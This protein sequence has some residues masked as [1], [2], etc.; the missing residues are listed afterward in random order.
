MLLKSDSYYTT[1]FRM[2]CSNKRSKLACVPNK[3][4]Q[5]KSLSTQL[6]YMCKY[7]AY[8]TYFHS[9]NKV[10]VDSS[11]V[12]ETHQS[13]LYE[14]KLINITFRPIPGMSIITQCN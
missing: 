1:S 7:F 12:G 3:V 10:S 9:R 5:Y 13:I 8:D 4:C 6:I 11:C 14:S 2:H